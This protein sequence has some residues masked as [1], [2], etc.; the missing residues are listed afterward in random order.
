M[1]GEVWRAKR[2][3]MRFADSYESTVPLGVRPSHGQYGSP[4]DWDVFTSVCDAR[5][6]LVLAMGKTPNP[7]TGH[8]VHGVAS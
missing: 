2:R 1:S 4:K 8:V 3:L 7:C 6:A 5:I